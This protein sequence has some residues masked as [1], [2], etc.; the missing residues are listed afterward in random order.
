MAP[1]DE[2]AQSFFEELYAGRDA[3]ANE[4]ADGVFLGAAKAAGDKTAMQKRR[5]S[6][7]LIAHP[8]LPEQHPKLFKYGRVP[9]IDVPSTNLLELLPDALAFLGAARGSGGRIFVYCAKGI[10]RSSSIVMALLMIERGIGFEEAWRLCEQKRPIVYP[11]IG[12]QQQLRHLE[13]L[14]ADMPP[15]KGSLWEETVARLR[16]VVPR[17]SLEGPGAPLQISDAI[18]DCMG[19]ALQ[20]LESLVEKVFTQPALLQKRELWKRQGLFFENLHKYKALPGSPELLD[21]A[22]AAADK[23]RSLPKVFSEALKG[24]KLGQAVA[25]EIEA[26]AAFAG[27]VLRATAPKEAPA[28]PAAVAVETVTSKKEK[29]KEKQDKQEKKEKKEKKEK[30]KKSKKEKK[31]EKKAEKAAK[32]AQKVIDK[33]EALARKAAEAAQGACAEA[34][35]AALRAEAA[36]KE[37]AELDAEES[38]EEKIAAA[39]SRGQ[40]SGGGGSG[41]AAAPQE[42]RPSHR[43]VAER[44]RTLREAASAS[45]S[46]SSGS[47]SDS[48]SPSPPAKRR[49]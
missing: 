30:E 19:Q 32:K 6:H 29:K 28:V 24:V 17:G 34:E 35:Q 21:A 41:R 12:F 45:G 49:R 27:P 33:T 25:K 39:N 38:Y 8:Q 7:V 46:D 40:G 5:I 23:L 16:K 10:S 13:G 22:K 47:D 42:R 18:G 1:R 36:E 43:E 14:L 31:L 15:A 26:W 44:M 9:L 2:T 11:N 4:I 20:D 48:G 3:D 37:L